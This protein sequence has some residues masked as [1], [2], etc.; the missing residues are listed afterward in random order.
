MSVTSSMWRQGSMHLPTPEDSG[1]PPNNPDYC[2]LRIR[3]T[4]LIEVR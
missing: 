4:H 2:I 3:R 1:M